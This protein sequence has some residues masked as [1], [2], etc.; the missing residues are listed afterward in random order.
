[1]Q[2][3]NVLQPM[4][5]DGFNLP[6]ENAAIKN[7]SH[8]AVWTRENIKHMRTQLQRIGFAFDWSRDFATCDPAYYRW[9]QWLF[10]QMYKR[11]CL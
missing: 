7:K 10:L 8:P 9:Q 6:A 1:M 11:S 3:H 5:W 2:G 4:G